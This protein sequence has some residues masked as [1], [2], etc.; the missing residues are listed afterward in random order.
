MPKLP[1]V[2]HQDAVRAFEKAGYWIIRQGKHIVMTNGINKLIIPRNNPINAI[3]MGAIVRD[4]G[5][6][7]EQFRQWL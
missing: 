2:N 1:G 4:A 6:T 5:M 3:T 7:N